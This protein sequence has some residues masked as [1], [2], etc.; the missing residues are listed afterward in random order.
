M[1]TIAEHNQVCQN[2]QEITMQMICIE[3]E[4]FVTKNI[5]SMEKSEMISTIGGYVTSGVMT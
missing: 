1:E 4:E 5:S 2:G 3:G